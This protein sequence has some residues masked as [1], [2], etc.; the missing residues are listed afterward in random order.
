MSELER[1]E[2]K[3]CRMEVRPHITPHGSAVNTNNNAVL[4]EGDW[5]R[6]EAGGWMAEGVG[7]KSVRPG[8]SAS[9]VREV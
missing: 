9:R 2:S 4:V 6:T 5:Q 3:V 8:P 1:T 7:I